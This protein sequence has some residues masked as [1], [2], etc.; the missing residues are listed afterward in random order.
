VKTSSETIYTVTLKEKVESI[1]I[2]NGGQSFTLNIG[3]ENYWEERTQFVIPVELELPE[4]ILPVVKN[5][6]ASLLMK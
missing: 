4:E 5:I 1:S 2:L 3:G 6:K